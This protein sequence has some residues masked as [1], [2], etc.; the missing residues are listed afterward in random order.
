MLLMENSEEESILIN[1]SN[2]KLGR[3]FSLRPIIYLIDSEFTGVIAAKSAKRR[4][5]VPLTYRY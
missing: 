2:D 5:I 4:C 3:I 1:K